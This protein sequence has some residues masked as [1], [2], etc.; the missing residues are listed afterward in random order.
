MKRLLSAFRTFGK[1]VISKMLENIKLMTAGFTS[2]SI[3]RH[4]TLLYT[5]TKNK[6]ALYEILIIITNFINPLDEK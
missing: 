3:R 6:Q 5:K 1:R 2:I 4:I